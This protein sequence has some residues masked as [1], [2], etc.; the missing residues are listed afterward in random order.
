MAGGG[1]SVQTGAVEKRDL[2]TDLGKGDIATLVDA[3]LESIRRG[4][5]EAG[6]KEVRF[7]E[8]VAEILPR[9]PA[10]MRFSAGA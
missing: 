5:L 1:R 8:S 3:L 10:P 9:S 4:E 6:P 7:L 2:E